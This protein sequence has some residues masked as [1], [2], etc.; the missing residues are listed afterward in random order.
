MAD[1]D[2]DGELAAYFIIL[3]SVLKKKKK[4][5]NQ[6][7]GHHN[8]ILTEEDNSIR[9][10]Q[11]LLADKTSGFFKNFT[12][13]SEE[14]FFL[15]LDCIKPRIERQ[16]TSHRKA[17][18]AEERLAL[19]LRFLATADSFTSLQY[20]FKVSK[21]L[22]SEIV[23]EVCQAIIECLSDYVQVPSTEE[24]WAHIAQQ[25]EN[26]WNFPKCV[27]AI[28]GKHIVLQAPIK[29]GSDYFIYKSHF[30][31]VVMATADADYNFTVVD[32]GCQGRISD[33]GVFSNTIL[34][35]KMDKQALNLPQPSPLNGREKWLPALSR[36]R[37]II[38]NT[39]DILSSVFRVLRKP[40][41]LEA[42]KAKLVV[43]AIVSLHNFTKKQNV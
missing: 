3:S 8:Y 27:G 19:T 20:L 9:I 33:G 28:D 17:I 13:M 11:D 32:I 5:K 14:D 10:A 24:K 25:F 30:S 22:I 37:R 35:I 31:I 42:E 6:N 26:V 34:S 40:M 36:A 4:R 29:S 41:L 23:P 43:M 12:R 18:S 39:F 2:S 15:L 38:E 7:D 21:Q 16:D 1:S